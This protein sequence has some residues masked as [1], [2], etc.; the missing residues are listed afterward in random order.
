MICGVLL[1][2]ASVKGAE[3]NIIAFYEVKSCKTPISI[4][5]TLNDPAW[6][7]ASRAVNYYE[8]YKINPGPGVLRT[9]FRMLYDDKGIY[10]AIINYD[11]NLDKIAAKYTTRDNDHLW[12]D[13]CAE[14]YFDP[15]G[16]GIGFTKFIVNSLAVQADM[17]RIDAAIALPC[18]NGNEWRAAAGRTSDAWIIE[19]FFPWGDLEK[20]AMPG[21]LWRF[22]HVRYAYTS[23]K[24]Q[25][26]T[27]SPGGNYTCPEKFGYL[28]FSDGKSMNLADVAGLM[29]KSASRPWSLLAGNDI[30][31]CDSSGKWKNMRAETMVRKETDELRSV[32][33]NAEKELSEIH[34][35]EAHTQYEILNAIK[36]D[37][38]AVPSN[39]PDTMTAM[40]V[41]R[42]IAELKHRA[43]TI[44][45]EARVLGLMGK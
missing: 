33:E 20:R 40:T 4:D 12:E 35:E 24:F 16:T 36:N 15:S 30:I 13:D 37:A 25:G 22:C 39:L 44:Y 45:W 3:M 7:T 5:G 28:Y 38:V 17:K 9:E 43:N 27:W 29:S 14:I 23:G 32:L 2:F 34:S 41:L 21:E 26:V 8:Y 10:L 6:E 19:A 11:S 18:W 31:L 42:K 1:G